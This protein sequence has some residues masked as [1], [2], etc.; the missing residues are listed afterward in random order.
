VPACVALLL[1]L[2]WP[3]A[4]A[5]GNIVASG[6]DHPD[7]RYTLFV[8]AHI[9]ASPQRVWRTIT[10]YARLADINPAFETSTVLRQDAKSVRVRTRIRV[11]ILVFCK[12]VIQVQDVRYPRA[13]EIVAEMVPGAGDFR[14][15]VAHWSLTQAGSGTRL[16]FDEWF[17][18]D[19][20]IPPVIGPWLIRRKL[21]QEVEVTMAHIEGTGHE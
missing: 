16:Q 14:T 4:A 17:V 2:L 9:D 12:S 6:V 5:A 19:F 20:W 7:E 1:V 13:Q 8:T 18:P 3:S 21:V 15:G 10:D 11:C